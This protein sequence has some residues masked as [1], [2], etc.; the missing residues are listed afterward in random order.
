MERWEY[1][2]VT[3]SYADKRKSWWVEFDDWDCAQDDFLRQ[4]GEDG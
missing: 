1:Y 3:I 4:M 2:A